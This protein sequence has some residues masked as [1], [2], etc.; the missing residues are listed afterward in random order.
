MS[1][2]DINVLKT[3]ASTVVNQQPHVLSL[4][5]TKKTKTYLARSLRIPPLKLALG[6]QA[7][8]HRCATANLSDRQGWRRR[9]RQ[10]VRVIFSRPVLARDGFMRSLY[11]RPPAPGHRPITWGTACMCR[12]DYC[13]PPRC[14]IFAPNLAFSAAVLSVEAMTGVQLFRRS[15]TCVLSNPQF[16]APRRF[17][18]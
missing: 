4:S 5:E 18:S 11:F 7:D 12:S 3:L 17:G 9:W 15:A 2:Q 16:P 13:L 1:C 14:L 10:L 8:A 6:C